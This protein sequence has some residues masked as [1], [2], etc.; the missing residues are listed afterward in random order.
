MSR[1]NRQVSRPSWARDWATATLLSAIVVTMADSLVLQRKRS[2][3]GGGFLAEDYLQGWAET[4]LFFVGSVLSDAGLAGALAAVGLLIAAK[5]RLGA[6]AR[7]AAAVAAAAG[8]LLTAVAAF[9]ELH[10]QIG[11]AF[12][13]ML[14]FELAGRR[15]EEFLAVASA[16]LLSFAAIVIVATLVVVALLWRVQRRFGDGAWDALPASPR[17]VFA[18]CLGLL[19]VSLSSSVGL[20]LGND[21]LDNGLRRK[22][23]GRLLGTVVEFLSDV[24]RDGYGLLGRPSDPAPWDSRVYPYALDVPGN[25]VDEDGVGGDLPS[26]ATAEA[27]RGD[28]W[29]A[30]PPIFGDRRPVVLVVLESV[31]AD[32]L[33]ASLDGRPVTPAL[34]AL[35]ARGGSSEAAYSHNGYTAQSR[36]HL[37]AGTLIHGPQRTTLLDDFKANGYE[38]AYFSAQDESFGGPDYDVGFTRADVRYDARQDPQLRY[39]TF[40]TQGSLAVSYRVLQRRISE[41]LHV[42]RREKPLFLYVNF[43]DAH[44]PYHHQDVVPL[45]TDV[46]LERRE[47]GPGRRD[48]LWRTYANT[49]ANVDKAVGEVL[50]DVASTTGLEPGVVVTSDHGESLYDSGFLGH[51][52]ALDDVQTRIPLIV[53]N[54][55]MRIREPFGQVD[56]R[57]A[58]LDAMRGGTRPPTPVVEADEGRPVFQ[59]L[60]TI[61]RPRQ[62]AFTT[63]AGRTIYDFR[64]GRFVTAASEGRWR[65][66]EELND[67][68]RRQ[69]LELLWTWER[70]AL[71]RASGWTRVPFPKE[72]Y[73]ACAA[74][75]FSSGGMDNRLTRRRCAG[76]RRPCATAGPTTTGGSWMGPLG[77]RFAGCRFSI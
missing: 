39:S 52:Y 31:R 47:I 54:L 46:A 12:D 64:D 60:G 9:H 4:S 68:D 5:V 23:S 28:E 51:G 25:G 21:S 29:T 57:R 3:F 15:P 7:R 16:H 32:V 72:W 42:R 30:P 61:D 33:E 50:Q 49:V 65:R 71:R 74:S 67:H 59:Y 20:R 11:G 6:A 73:A 18:L 2:L 43:H 19:L 24:D 8:P 62:I 37:L 1:T 14:M 76:C 75:R 77:S 10:V 13:F 26:L 34:R 69:F 17:R 56:L 63:R 44:F 36:F 40:A 48:E 27:A 55:P 38:V 45:V 58:L 70:L 41:F 53:S 66:T 35:A 22:P